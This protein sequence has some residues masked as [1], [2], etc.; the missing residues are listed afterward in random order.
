MKAIA[1]SVLFACMSIWL[2]AGLQAQQVSDVAGTV[3]DQAGKVIPGASVDVKNES[4]ASV[5]KVTTGDDGRFSVIG[6]PAGNYTL[7]VTAPGFAVARRTGVEVSGGRAEDLS[8]PLSVASVNQSVTVEAVVSLAAQLAPSGN[9]LDAT[10]AKTEITGQF[11]RNFTSP[12]SDF[13]EV[14]QMAPGT[15]SVNSNG[16]GLG[17]GKTFFRGFKDGNYSMTFDGIPF[18][19][20]N[21]PTHHFL[22]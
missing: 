13:N 4:G 12:L 16:V 20:T 19:D 15:Y 1:T 9:T 17:Q 21:D 3:L 8:I 18:Q 14:I 2:P 7:E 6:L 5:R 10:S 22:L 11:I